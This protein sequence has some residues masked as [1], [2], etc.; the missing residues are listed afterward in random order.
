VSCVIALIVGAFTV[1][2]LNAGSAMC[3]YVGDGQDNFQELRDA[4]YAS[5]SIELRAIQ[6]VGAVI[7]AFLLSY[8]LL[9]VL[10][11]KKNN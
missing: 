5:Y 11:N 8:W 6:A 3:H 4:C 9:K 7:V 1:A 10:I 2:V